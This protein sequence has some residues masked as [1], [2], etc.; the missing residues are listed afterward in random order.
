M[1]RKEDLFERL[2]SDYEYLFTHGYTPLF[3]AVQ[4]SDNYGLSDEYSDIDTK[5]VVIPNFEDVCLNRKPVSTTH[6]L[7]DNSHLDIKD[8]RLMHECYL[9]QN[10]NFL[11]VLFTPYR[12]VN[13]EFDELY[14]P[15]FQL[16]D[17]VAHYNNY[18][19]VQ[20]IAG[21]VFEK[22]KY[23]LKETPAQVEDIHKYG[24]APKQL[25]HMIRCHDFL[26]KYISGCPYVDCLKVR[27]AEEL[28]KI[29][30]GLLSYEEAVA[31]AELMYESTVTLKEF[32]MQNVPLQINENAKEILQN[33]L[34]NIFKK[35]FSKQIGAFI[36]ET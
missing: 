4:G 29:K 12:I 8:I 36:Y 22:Y 25:H 16:A 30:R 6:V 26:I 35:H 31:T 10:I 14:D 11:E 9:K 19:A 3:V 15:V 17:E 18:K 2:K 20:S 5:A 33:C 1:S 13:R 27:N 32:Y 23:L 28:I 34:I 24:Y 7:E 21:M